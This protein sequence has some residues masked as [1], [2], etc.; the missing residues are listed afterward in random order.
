MAGIQRVIYCNS[1]ELE[2]SLVF[3]SRLYVFLKIA[4]CRSND[5]GVGLVKTRPETKIDP[6]F[7]SDS[8]DLS[9]LERSNKMTRSKM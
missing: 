3:R 9:G 6:V 8:S 2:K 1:S 4:F 7:D 5:P